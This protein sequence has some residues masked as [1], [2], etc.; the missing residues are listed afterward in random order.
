VFKKLD[1]LKHFQ[2]DYL[3][4]LNRKEK[5][6]FLHQVKKMDETPEFIDAQ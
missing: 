6:Y 1:N 5:K 2:I 4:R 3:V